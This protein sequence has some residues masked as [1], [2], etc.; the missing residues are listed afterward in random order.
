MP[1][2]LTLVRASRGGGDGQVAPDEDAVQRLLS[3]R[4]IDTGSDEA[5]VV[6]VGRVGAWDVEVVGVGPRLSMV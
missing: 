4:L 3:G 6:Q 1:N 2:V 5:V